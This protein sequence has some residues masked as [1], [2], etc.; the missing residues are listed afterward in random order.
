MWK[1]KKDMGTQNYSNLRGTGYEDRRW[2][3]LDQNYVQWQALAEW[4]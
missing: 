1:T 4:C 2:M 3:K